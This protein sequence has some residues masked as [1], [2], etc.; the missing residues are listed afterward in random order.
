[1]PIANA[2]YLE[3]FSIAMKKSENVNKFEE[4]AESERSKKKYL[5]TLANERGV[6]ILATSISEMCRRIPISPASPGQQGV[7]AV[8]TRSES[9]FSGG[10]SH[11]LFDSL[12]S[13]AAQSASQ[14]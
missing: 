3:T 6:G 2:F 11:G 4:N 12:G 14:R 9:P 13:F 1:V 10:G 5:K 7:A 8:S